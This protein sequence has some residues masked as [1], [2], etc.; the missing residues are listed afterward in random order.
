MRQYLTGTQ[1]RGKRSGKR[2]RAIAWMDSTHSPCV[3][4]QVTG[5][6]KTAQAGSPGAHESG[7]PMLPRP[8]CCHLHSWGKGR[9]ELE[10]WH[11]AQRC[12]TSC[13]NKGGWWGIGAGGAAQSPGWSFVGEMDE[14][15]VS[16]QGSGKP[17]WCTW[18]FRAALWRQESSLQKGSLR[19]LFPYVWIKAKASKYWL[20]TCM[21]VSICNTSEEREVALEEL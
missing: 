20:E 19:E 8:A 5:R 16:L 9:A 13:V 10:G 2:K 17:R 4:G 1:K 14:D 11:P 18:H 12:Q 15:A 7:H 3:Q 6:H 21:G